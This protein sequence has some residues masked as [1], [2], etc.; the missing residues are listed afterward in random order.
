MHPGAVVRGRYVIQSPALSGGMGDV[1]RALDRSSGAMVAIKF[2]RGAGGTDIARFVREA[3]ILSQLHHPAIVRH[4]DNGVTSAGLVYLVT[5]WLDGQTLAERLREESLGVWE[6][7]ALARDVA[8]GLAEVHARGLIHRDVKPGN[9]FLVEGRTDGVRLIDFGLARESAESEEP[10]TRTG[11]GV[12]TPA[13]VA[14]EQARGDGEVDGRADIYSL[15]CVLFRCITGSTPSGAAGRTSGLPPLEVLLGDRAGTLPPGLVALMTSMLAHDPGKRPRDGRALA[16][17]IEA[18]LESAGTIELSERPSAIPRVS[19]RE[20]KFEVLFAARLAPMLTGS[21]LASRLEVARSRVASIGAVLDLVDED[22]IVFELQERNGALVDVENAAACAF[23]TLRILDCTRVAI[24]GARQENVST[25][26]ELRARAEDL[27]SANAPGAA[28][29]ADASSGALLRSRY[30]VEALDGGAF[31]LRERP[32]TLPP[33]RPGRAGRPFVGRERELQFLTTSFRESVRES[34]ACVVVVTGPPG[35][36]KSRLRHELGVAIQEQG[37]SLFVS[38]ATPLAS[39]VALGLLTDVIVECGRAV[40]MT[41]DGGRGLAFDAWMTR[42]LGGDAPRHAPFIAELLRLPQS[43][44][45]GDLASARSDGR[46]MAR[47]VRDA[48]T[49]LLRWQARERPLAILLDDIQWADPASIEVLDAVVLALRDTSIFIA[50]FGRPESV[51]LHGGLDRARA[52]TVLR[53][54]PLTPSAACELAA[55][56]APGEHVSRLVELAQGHPFVLEELARGASSGTAELRSATAASVAEARVL[57]LDA[58]DRRCLRAASIFGDQVPFEGIVMLLGG[59]KRRRRIETWARNLVDAELLASAA[60]DD[61]LTVLRFRHSLIQEAAYS[62]LTVEDRQRGH[63]VAAEILTARGEPAAIVGEHYERAGDEGLAASYFLRASRAASVLGAFE[64][65]QR[66]CTRALAQTTDP[67][68]RAEIE[69]ASCEAHKWPG[70]YEEMLSAAERALALA[71]PESL[72]WHQAMG[73][74]MGAAASLGDDAKV[75]AFGARLMTCEASPVTGERTRCLARAVWALYVVGATSEGAAMTDAMERAQGAWDAPTR[76]SVARARAIRA[77]FEPDWES[78]IH[79][80]QVAA[81]TY[82]L[83]GHSRQ[84]VNAHSNVGLYLARLG[85]YE[86]AVLE[87]ERSDRD[88]RAAE[89]LALSQTLAHVRLF[90]CS[91]T[92][93]HSSFATA[94]APLLT[95][96]RDTAGFHRVELLVYAAWGQVRVGAFL[97]AERHARTALEI[98][99]AGGWEAIALACLALALAGQPGRAA[100]AMEAAT[101]AR[102]AHKSG[103]AV[104]WGATFV[105][106]SEAVALASAGRDRDA[107]AAAR[108]GLDVVEGHAAAIRDTE[109]RRGFLERLPEHQ[110]LRRLAAGGTKMDARRA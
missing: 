102:L 8:R 97:D 85:A 90:I 52:M 62:L 17:A 66:W 94:L 103:P 25:R 44:A 13:Y 93:D 21:G 63:R 106:L 39:G 48:V 74:A 6:S 37:G 73:E 64:M 1:F 78:T 76:A 100:E 70:E 98:P 61:E 104:E 81:E 28:V 4:V 67:I 15:G 35:I 53:L 31:V 46:L 54:A 79:W 89:M 49:A 88:C 14:P 110:W 16:L 96:A 20:A 87:I 19:A 11:A 91:Q 5:E 84:A 32:N 82:A 42:A 50:W 56:L 26:R 68:V 75:R 43:D 47:R 38:R 92:G 80:Y 18:L 51:A 45:S 105:R 10:V 23:E 57:A 69:I 99:E 95:A 36:G 22:T 107:T 65:A 71:P 33:P 55:A 77:S 58:D 83:C 3:T 7:V 86:R 59:E 60:P 101:R 2:P 27:L 12:G 24:V 72:L 40:G 41:P 29:L 108:R 34:T 30:F 109:L 9:L